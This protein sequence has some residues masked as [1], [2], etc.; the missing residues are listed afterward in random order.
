MLDSK[1]GFDYKI[2]HNKHTYENEVL[3]LILPQYSEN[4]N[5]LT[6]LA[7]GHD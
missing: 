2:P 6:V 1:Y 5:R 7:S 3:K 4:P